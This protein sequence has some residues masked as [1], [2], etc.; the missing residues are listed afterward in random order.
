M[1]KGCHE[2]CGGII[3]KEEELGSDVGIKRLDYFEVIFTPFKS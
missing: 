1:S 2:F 3:E